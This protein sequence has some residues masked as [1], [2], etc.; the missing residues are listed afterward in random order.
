MLGTV[1]PACRG[2]TKWRQVNTSGYRANQVGFGDFDGDGTTDVFKANG[3]TWMVSYSATSRWTEINTSRVRTAQMQFADL[4][5]DGRTDVFYDD[6]DE[7]FAS[8]G[9]A[10]RWRTIN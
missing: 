10:S 9:G 3:K 4:D 5:G 7:W 6:G 1:E 8:W 2:S